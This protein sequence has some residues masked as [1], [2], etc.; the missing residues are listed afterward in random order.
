MRTMS[1]RL[2]I[3]PLRTTSFKCFFGFD[4][5][6]DTYKVVMVDSN[7]DASK[8]RIFNSGDNIWREIEDFPTN[9]YEDDGFC[10]RGTLNWLDENEIISLNLGIETCTKMLL[11]PGFDEVP[12]TDPHLALLMECL[13]FCHDSKGTHFIIRKMMEFGITESWT[14]L[15]KV[16]YQDL[17]MYQIANNVPIHL[18]PLYIYNGVAVIFTSFDEDQVI[19]YNMRDNRVER[20]RFTIEEKW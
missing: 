3:F 10:F 15:L 5:S 6:I 9:V 19:V 11:P 4:N 1:D 7:N 13:C 18:S 8:V 17:H 20:T 14:Q 12:H 16:R 2:G